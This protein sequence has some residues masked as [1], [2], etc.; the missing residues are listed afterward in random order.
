VIARGA[1]LLATIVAIFACGD[2][3]DPCDGIDSA[4]VVVGV[5]SSIATTIDGLQ[6]DIS[7]GTFHDTLAI[8]TRNS[9]PTPLPAIT[10][11][12]LAPESSVTLSVLAA[13]VLDGQIVGVGH[14]TTLV[15]GSG[16]RGEL[17]IELAA[18]P[19]CVPGSNYCGR[20]LIP[21][22]P[23]VLYRCERDAV[24]VARGRCLF[25]CNIVSSGED[26]CDSG[27][28]TCVDGGNYCGG[29]KIDGD[30]QV[31]YVC[32]NGTGTQ[33]TPCG[34]RCVINPPGLDDACEP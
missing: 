6:L 13:G 10:S 1:F 28:N 2:S 25:G 17:A 8:T 19:S 20:N 24:P 4:C 32:A 15:L 16:A 12:E 5:S 26:H 18:A 29:D 22:E 21:G 7:Y 11:I 33:P 9:E 31:L 23:D 14:D 27:P 3:D 30:P 34:E